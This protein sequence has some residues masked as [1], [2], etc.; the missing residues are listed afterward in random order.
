MENK[1][2]VTNGWNLSQGDYKS[3]G[4]SYVSQHELAKKDQQ[5][6][7]AGVF[8]AFGL[9]ATVLM[10]IVMTLVSTIKL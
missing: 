9:V 1:L 3:D 2:S 4:A 6:E 5:R 7:R 8:I 10:I